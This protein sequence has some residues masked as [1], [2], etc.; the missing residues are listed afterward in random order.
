MGGLES[1]RIVALMGARGLVGLLIF[2]GQDRMAAA[3]QIDAAAG[4]GLHGEP[5]AIIV[6]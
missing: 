3:G 5:V 1:H 2:D 4:T 6:L